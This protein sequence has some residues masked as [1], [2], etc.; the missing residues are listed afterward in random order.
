MKANGGGTATGNEGFRDV[1]PTAGVSLQTGYIAGSPYY[2]RDLNGDG[3]I[4]D[5]VRV[6]APSQTQTRR[7]GVIAGLRYDSTTIIP[8]AC[9]TA[10]IAP[11][12]ARPAKL[13]L[14]LTAN[15]YVFAVNDPLADNNGNVLQKRDRQSIALLT[16][17]VANIAANV[18]RLTVQ[19]GGASSVHARPDQQLRH[20]ERD[21]LCRMFRQHADRSAQPRHHTPRGITAPIQGPQQ[22][23]QI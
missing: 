21:G 20:V 13:L 17:F 8:S 18:D 9:S 7:Y 2:G 10:M 14:Q 19:V 6:L 16:M 1:D 5:T 22:R 11:V 15:R 4:L 3:D 23:A 12:T